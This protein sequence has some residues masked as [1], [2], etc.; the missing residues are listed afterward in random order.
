[1]TCFETKNDRNHWWNLN[2][3]KN[4]SGLHWLHYVPLLSV[5]HFG[6]D[7]SHFPNNGISLRSLRTVKSCQF[8]L[9]FWFLALARKVISIFMLEYDAWSKSNLNVDSPRKDV[10][11]QLQ[12]KSAADVFLQSLLSL[13]AIIII[14]SKFFLFKGIRTERTS[15]LNNVS[16]CKLLLCM[17][18]LYRPVHLNFMKMFNS[19]NAPARESKGTRFKAI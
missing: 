16:N 1:M 19:G 7:R 4:L 14:Y 5:V 12:C 15:L 9:K 2:A 13:S 10:W 11:T 17:Y 3:M 8:S 6:L 18:I